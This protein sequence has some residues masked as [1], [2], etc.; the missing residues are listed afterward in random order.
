RGPPEPLQT[1]LEPRLILADFE[2]LERA[3][4]LIGNFGG[5]LERGVRPRPGGRAQPVDGAV[6]RNGHEPR[7][8]ACDGLIEARRLPPHREI[9]VLQHVL[10]LASVTQ[11]TKTDA[12]KLRRGF[13][14]NEA[15]SGAIAASD[16]VDRGD[17]LAAP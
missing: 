16:P 6:P 7:D 12:E 17:K 9:N 8:R 15:Q 2:P 10:S 4:T 1:V 11:D 13:L 5:S 14:I 3:Q